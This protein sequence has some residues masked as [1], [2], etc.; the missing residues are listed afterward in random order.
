MFGPKKLGATSLQRKI[1]LGT[2][3]LLLLVVLVWRGGAQQ[4]GDGDNEKKYPTVAIT[5][6]DATK[7]AKGQ[8]AFGLVFDKTTPLARW[9]T[10][11]DSID[12]TAAF[13]AGT[14]GQPIARTIAHSVFVTATKIVDDT[15]FL[16]LS[17]TP[18]EA[19]LLSFAIANAR[20][21][22]AICPAGPDIDIPTRGVT[23][24]DI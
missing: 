3:V 10:V 20:I 16:V 9:I 18:E 5:S 4:R 1:V 7:P 14:E 24:N 12:I 11:G 13:P 2:T 19:E 17:I 21:S 8:R 6:N 15:A 22:I 23:F